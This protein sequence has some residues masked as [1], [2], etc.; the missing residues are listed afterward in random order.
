LDSAL[1]RLGQGGFTKDGSSKV[2]DVRLAVPLEL[3]DHGG[4][5][6]NAEVHL[7]PAARA[8]RGGPAAICFHV[9]E[10]N[11]VGKEL[12]VVGP[13]AIGKPQRKAVPSNFARRYETAT[14]E[15]RNGIRLRRE[16]DD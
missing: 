9:D 14:R 13:L 5:A 16:V 2:F 11:C 12:K 1:R 3:A 7:V 8:N 10:P 6:P 15:T 4:S